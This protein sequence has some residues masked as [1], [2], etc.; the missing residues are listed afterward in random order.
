MKWNWG[1]GLVIGMAAFM[2]FILQYVIRVQIDD[3]YDNELVTTDYYQKEIHIDDNYNAEKNALKLGEKL[4]I[5]IHDNGVYINFPDEWENEK[6]NGTISLYR[7]SD[8]KLDHSLPIQLT[9]SNNLLIPKNLL[10][11]GRWD[12]SLSFNYENTSYLK[13]ETLNL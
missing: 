12:I 4:N 3:K 9:D 11:G 2:I 1:T 6:V 8:Q 7:P 5:K 10:A 13:K